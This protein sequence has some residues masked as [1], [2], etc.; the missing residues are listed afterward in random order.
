MLNSIGF[1]DFTFKKL[2]V[3][4]G[5]TEAGIYRY[6]ENKHK[7]LTYLVTWFWTW[8]EYQLIF[9]TN[10]ITDTKAKVELVVKLLTF[11]IEDRFS[12]GHI[13][14]HLLYWVVV[15]EG[16]KAYLTKH[17]EADNNL[18]IFKPYKDLSNRIAGIFTE[19]TSKYP[20]PHSLASTL[21]ETCHHQIYFK[22][23]LPSLTDF[24]KAKDF[25][26]VEEFL[27]H[28]VFSALNE[29]KGGKAAK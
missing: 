24:G 22:D 12:V 23:N 29:G 19:Y 5:T 4:V 27:L 9:H 7:L 28:L 17:I 3:R 25:K 20:F 13:D 8:L 18:R 16:N 26:Q 2:A 15:A 1:E 10:N 14:K 21:I 6:F 11:Q